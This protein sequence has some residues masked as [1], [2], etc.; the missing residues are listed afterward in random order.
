MPPTFELVVCITAAAL[1]DCTEAREILNRD[2]FEACKEHQRANLMVPHQPGVGYPLVRSLLAL[3]EA[4]EKQL[5]EVVLI[6]CTDSD[7]GERIRQSIHHYELPITHEDQVRTVLC[8]TSSK[9]FTGIAAALVCSIVNTTPNIS[10]NPIQIPESLHCQESDS[11]LD[12]TVLPSEVNTSTKYVPSASLPYLSWP[13]GQVR[14]AFDGDS[15]LFSDQAECVFKTEGLEGFF[16][17]ERKHGHIAL[18]KGPMQAFALKFQ[19]LR[20]SLGENHKWRVRTFLVTARNDVYEIERLFIYVRFPP[21][22]QHLLAFI[23]TWAQHV[24][25]YGQVYCY[26]GGY[27]WAILCAYICHTYLSPIKSLSSIEHF[28]I[29]EFFSL[30]Q[31]IFSTF[32]QF[33]WSSQELCLYS[34]SYKQMTL[35]NK[36]SVHN[37]GSMRIISP[38]PPYNNTGRSTTN[39]TRDLIIQEFQCVLQLLDSVNIITCEDKMNALKQ[40]LELNNDFPNE[41]TKSLLQLTLSSENIH[42]IDEWIGWIKSRLVRFVN[43][44][45]EECHLIIQTQCS[46]EYQSNNTEAFYSLAFQLDPQTLDQHQNFF[47]CLKKCLHQFNLYPNRKTSM[48]VSYKIVSIHDWKLERMQP[49]LQRII[50]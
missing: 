44:C 25:L 39:S 28:S 29:D 45:E 6:S 7:S 49:K 21:I 33:N 11:K 23:R 46:I 1:F 40:I 18:P 47:R 32:A 48:K 3:N 31:K 34:K 19:K 26:L 37:R 22:F 24:G 36:S 35:S 5:V 4:A 50:K 20:Q 12:M 17:F 43:D 9:A 8:G 15:V 27:S 13:E 10:S 42:E 30:V 38:S 16:E 14:I 2:G 41:K